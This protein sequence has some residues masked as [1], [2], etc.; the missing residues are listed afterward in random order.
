MFFDSSCLRC[1]ALSSRSLGF[2][3]HSPSLN[4]PSGW[5][6]RWWVPCCPASR[7]SACKPWQHCPKATRAD[8][9]STAVFLS[10]ASCTRHWVQLVSSLSSDHLFSISDVR[11]KTLCSSRSSCF[12][13]TCVGIRLGL[14]TSSWSLIFV[15]SSSTSMPR[16]TVASLTCACVFV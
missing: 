12:G 6:Y 2:G 13:L 16:R 1:H 7:M 14:C 11:P 8:S 10:P 4:Q 9:P 3:P 5:S 15:S